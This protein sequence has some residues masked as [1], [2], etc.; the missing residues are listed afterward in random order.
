VRACPAGV[1][2]GEGQVEAWLCPAG[3]P[4]AQ[5]GMGGKIKAVGYSSWGKPRLC[6]LEVLSSTKWFLPKL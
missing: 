2:G 1:G 6:F 3:W 5:L 4:Q